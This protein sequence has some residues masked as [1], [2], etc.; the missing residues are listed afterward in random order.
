VARQHEKIANQRQDFLHKI[1]RRIVNEVGTIKIENLNVC[2]MLR[3]HCLAKSIS[4]SGWGMFG[5][6]LG[7]KEALLIFYGKVSMYLKAIGKILPEQ[8]Q[9]WIGS[10]LARHADEMLRH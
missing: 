6:F 5:N 10:V 9:E 2:G 3:N 7:Y 1:S 4:D 8:W